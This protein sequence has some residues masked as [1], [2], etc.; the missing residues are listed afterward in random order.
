MAKRTTW[1]S[2]VVLVVLVGAAMV[3]VRQLRSTERK[4]VEPEK[5][6]MMFAVAIGGVCKVMSDG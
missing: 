6:M 3:C 5:N 4:M 2:G 1:K